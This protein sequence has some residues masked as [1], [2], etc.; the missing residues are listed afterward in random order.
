MAFILAFLC[1]YIYNYISD[2]KKERCILK[3]P[4][5]FFFS[6]EESDTKVANSRLLSYAAGLAGQNISYSF[7]SQRLFVFMNTVLGI[8]SKKTGM[9]TGISTLWDAINDPL[10]GTL[11][12]ARKFK[13]GNKLRPLV[14]WTSPLAGLFIALMF[15]DYNLSATATVVL[16]LIL[17]LLFDLI[18]SFQDV[19]MWGLLPLSSPSSD[20]RAR[21]S[22]W[23]TIGAGLGATI[24]GAFPMVRSLLVDNKIV[25]EKSAYAIGGIVFGFGGMLIALLAYRMRE[26]V[27]Y[28]GE[29]EVSV[30]ESV[31]SLRHN[32]KL[33]IIC[34]ARFLG[35]L[36]LSLPWE[37]FF[38][39]DGIV[40]NFF[41]MELSGG[42]MQVIHG[43]VPG[44]PGAFAMF[45]ATKFAHKIGGMKRVL[46]LS[47]ALQIICRVS[48]FAI[49]ANDRFLNPAAL[50]PIW[51]L[52]AICNIPIS[53]KD[54]AHRSLI[55]DSI[56]EVELKTGERTEGIV[57]SMQ[58]F[59]SKLSSAA[60]NF[61]KGIM[62]SKMGFV[63]MKDA[64]GEAID[65]ARLI[66]MQSKNTAFYKYRW[67]Q[68]MLGPVV[69]SVLYLITI[70]FL[71]DDREHM[72]E[73]ERQLKEKRAQIE[74]EAL[75]LEA[76]EGAE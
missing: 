44:I 47:E 61:I 23:V 45:F 31:K 75:A 17:Y 3:N 48:A 5:K 74:A 15:F 46:V 59:I 56:D 24:G 49:G 9:I 51:V 25:S 32:K 54:I 68:F 18:Y 69:G 1:I 41:G 34:L 39:T 8:D 22:Q 2:E 11:V 62:L 27:H 64:S 20:E 26:K 58:N 12:D 50:I 65:G 4:F 73:V 55:S 35:S 57:F 37:Y 66:R 21:V 33:L 43:L 13:P 71:N 60:T 36:S 42:T 53:M 29:K 76:L 30:I 40:Y 70:L 19:A 72:A 16:M 7:I 63:N 6:K 52:L 67:H 38:E 28:E 14:I 10:V